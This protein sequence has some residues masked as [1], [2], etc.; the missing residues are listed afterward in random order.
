M[1]QFIACLLLALLV[2]L[3]VPLAMPTHTDAAEAVSLDEEHDPELVAVLGHATEIIEARDATNELP[4][5][6]RL[7][8]ID[9]P[10]ECG[11]SPETCPMEFLY[12][13]ASELGEYEQAQIFRLPDAYGWTF[14][15]WSESVEQSDATAVIGL[16]ERGSSGRTR[17]RLGG[18]S[19]ATNSASYFQAMQSPRRFMRLN[20][21]IRPRVIVGFLA[22]PLLPGALLPGFDISW[23]MVDQDMS[24]VEALRH[25]IE[26]GLFPLAAF[27]VLIVG[28]YVSMA[29]Y[30]LV[31]AHLA[32]RGGLAR[33]SDWLLPERFAGLSVCRA[34]SSS[35]RFGLLYSDLN[36]I[37]ACCSMSCRSASP[38]V[39]YLRRCSGSSRG[40]IG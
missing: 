32:A 4:L 11:D 1:K 12:V 30:G 17:R 3:F 39:P 22:P 16:L 31:S 25:F 33:P 37:S 38:W 29:L 28:S 40:R 26:W 19:S 7:F 15:G 13:V 36:R 14:E 5:H 10:G 18:L 23:R 24:P 6:L 34:G 27:K 35:S 20:E 21:M 9:A 2:Q 8:R